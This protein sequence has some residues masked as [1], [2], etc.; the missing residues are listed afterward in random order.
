[1]RISSCDEE[2]SSETFKGEL[3][4]QR[5]YFQDFLFDEDI[6]VP[7]EEIP[8]HDSMIHLREGC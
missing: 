3:K 6:K 8:T 2:M 1:M 4:P 7:E 5:K